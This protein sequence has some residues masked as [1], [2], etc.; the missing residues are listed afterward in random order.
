MFED[1]SPE[2]RAILE[3]EREN[4]IRVAAFDKWQFHCRINYLTD[5]DGYA[6]EAFMEG[7]HF[8]RSFKGD[9]CQS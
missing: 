5:I 7:I 3:M 2:E 8:A 1:H 9:I 6:W 4:A